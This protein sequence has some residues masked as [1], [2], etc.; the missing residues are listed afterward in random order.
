M[1]DFFAMLNSLHP[2]SQGLKKHL[3][4]VLKTVNIRKKNFLLLEGQVCNNICYIQKGLI[5]CF[6]NI[7]AE[8]VCSWFMTEQNLIVSV[9]SFF[10][11]KPSYES[12]Q[13]L[14]DCTLLCLSYGE[15]QGAYRTFPELNFI[16]R[17]LTE[18]YYVLSEQ[19]LYSLRKKRAAERYIFLRENFP[20][21][22]QRVPSKYLS[23]YLS[24][25]EE[26]LSRIKSK[27]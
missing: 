24:V 2:M 3:S 14:E 9:E 6:Y 23:S 15:L 22:V 26:T 8:E 12:I 20:E 18:K 11:Q 16:A 4:A 1:E 25:S 13:A 19:R 27:I 7:N 21:L 17:V 10:A 5:R